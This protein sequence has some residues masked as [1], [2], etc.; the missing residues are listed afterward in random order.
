MHIAFVANKAW[1]IYNF[2]QGIVRALL[3][4]GN[5]IT[6]IAPEDEQA[7]QLQNIGCIFI[8]IS[9][10][11]RGT[12]PIQDLRLTYQLYRIYK[13]IHADCI[14]HFTI[15]PN[16]Y[17]SIAARI[18]GI[19]SISTVSGLGTVFLHKNISSKIAKALY[20]FTFRFPKK[21]FFQNPDDLH[22][23]VDQKLVIPSIASIL[24]GSGINTKKYTIAPFKKNNPFRYL[25]IGR[26]LYDKGVVEYV[27]AAKIL[28]EKQLSVECQILG[29]TAFEE[30][31]GILEKELTHWIKENYITYLGSTDNVI[32]YIQ[33]SDCVVLP[34]YREGVPR[35]L[36]EAAAL[37]KPLIATNVPGCKEIVENEV[38]GLLCKVKDASDLAEKMKQLYETSNEKLLQ[39]GIN[40][41]KKVEDQFEEKIVI[42]KYIQAINEVT[43]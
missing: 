29:F 16:I 4:L 25:F 12:H 42:D 41:R 34:S 30:K 33:Q 39:W 37:G 19:P 38:N 7:K 14:F 9:I 13:K 27:E 1:N 24:P 26:L 32:N 2:R 36:L 8:P 15:K 43:K 20:R 17:G 28:K 40:S 11:S 23:F 21:I 22:L 5:Q 3:Q 31:G 6:I 35:T 18:A 10:A